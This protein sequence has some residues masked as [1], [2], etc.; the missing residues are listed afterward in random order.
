M[1]PSG[2]ILRVVAEN[3]DYALDG[4][5]QLAYERYREMRPLYRDFAEPLNSS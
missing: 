5:L 1:N 2:V 3:Q 4:R